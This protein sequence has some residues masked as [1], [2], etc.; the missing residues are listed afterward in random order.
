MIPE[1]VI[2]TV[3][4]RR[5]NVEKLLRSLAEQTLRP[6]IVTLV[7]DDYAGTPEPERPGAALPIAVVDTKRRA[8]A[9][10]RWRHIDEWSNSDALV[11]V[12]DDDMAVRPTYVEHC[13]ATYERL[14]APFSWNG[15]TFDEK[16]ISPGDEPIA[17]RRLFILGAGTAVIP[18]RLLRGI[19]KDPQAD[20]F[21]GVL[22]D[23]EALVS[24]WLANQ[25]IR[26]HRPRGKSGAL[27]TKFQL[28]PRSQYAQ[29]PYT[30]RN[31]IAHFRTSL[32]QRGWPIVD[33]PPE[34][35]HPR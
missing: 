34:Y 21:F 31:N 19:S 28:D 2:A 13:V 16:W 22:G 25:G 8:G 12:I 23:D 26:L 24:W 11:I 14:Q 7:L 3:P 1:V 29:R 6:G 33:P 15:T 18:A 17:D 9:G 30:L 4:W 27:S 35:G 20:G 32:K 10:F 5:E